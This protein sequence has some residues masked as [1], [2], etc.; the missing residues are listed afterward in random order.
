[1][2]VGPDAGGHTSCCDAVVKG[3]LL[4]YDIVEPPNILALHASGS[5]RL[6]TPMLLKLEGTGSASKRLYASLQ[7]AIDSGV[8]RSGTKIPSTR[9][10]AR[11]LGVSRKAVT[12]AFE[13]LA[14]EG[15]VE[16]R[17]G[18]GTFVC[19]TRPDAESA[20]RRPSR[21]E[22]GDVVPPRLSQHA[23]RVLAQTPWP[24]AGARPP[25]SLPYDFHYGTPAI[26]DF[27]HGTW[28]R[29]IAARARRLSMPDVRYGGTLGHRPLRVAIAEHLRRSRGLDASA[30][31]V[32]IVNGSQHG[33]DLLVRLLI[34]PGDYVAIEEPG[35]QAARQAMVAAGARIIPIPVDQHG[36]DVAQLPRDQRVRLTYV[37]PS[38]Q[39]PLGGVLPL[40]RRVELLRWAAAADSFI[41]ED[42]Y[43]S[44]FRYDGRP[45]EAVQALDRSERVL[46]V[47][48]F[49][50]V[51]FP[52]I[53]IGYLV[54]PPSLVAPV[55]ALRLLGDYHT[56]TF[57]QA[58]LADFIVN[59]H[60]D[61]HLRRARVRNARKRAALLAALRVSFGSGV[62][63]EGENAGVHVVVWLRDLDASRVD[64][65]RRQ[66][67]T[68]GVGIYDVAPYYV[69]P[70]RGAGLL[71]G[72]AS[73]DE[74]EIHEGVTLLRQAVERVQRK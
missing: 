43:D 3:W 14:A 32:V 24:P 42:D 41:V 52:S 65:L 39:F 50:K 10:L 54:L 73:L 51:L 66:A 45:L 59:G 4:I 16:M 2:A 46:Y 55:A 31:Q 69:A 17:V 25:G 61:S 21:R 1:V 44:E 6:G 27:P 53:R 23:Q 13:R 72:Y 22:R 56:P 5:M 12:R 35:Y 18:S 58:A 62:E 11:D 19:I 64:R 8:L 68:M 20:P 47:G 37:T 63:V 38:H 48:T 57:Q 9:I 40:D 67:A 30:D 33:L 74:R 26:F 49:S 36:M 29:L 60:F 15:Y 34:D 28:A 7:R 70:P 71:V